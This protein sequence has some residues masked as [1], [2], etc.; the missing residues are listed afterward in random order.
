MVVDYSKAKIYKIICNTTGEQYFGSTTQTLSQRLTDHKCGIRRKKKCRSSQIIERN[1]FSILLVESCP[2]EN[3][4]QLMAR[5]R[6]HI[7]NNDCVNKIV[8]A[9]TN[10]E[11]L[12]YCRKY[13]IKNREKMLSKSIEY[14]WENREKIIKRKSE[15]YK[16]KKSQLINEDNISINNQINEKGEEITSNVLD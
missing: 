10:E 9:R 3:R 7:E 15:A 8:P 12:E 1:N 16:N 11:R 13:Y 4:E 2:C 14:H 5:E 6:F